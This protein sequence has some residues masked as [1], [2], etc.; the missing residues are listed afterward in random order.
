M[1]SGNKGL[2]CK[3]QACV[4]IRQDAR[5]LAVKLQDETNWFA[6][7]QM[8]T[9]TQSQE[10]IA[11]CVAKTNEVRRERVSESGRTH[12]FWLLSYRMKLIVSHNGRCRL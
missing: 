8:Q 3:P 7:W 12:G 11:P 9:V 2:L 10:G 6:L 4:R 1:Q 5:I